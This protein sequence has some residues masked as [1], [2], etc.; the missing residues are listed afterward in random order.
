VV[1]ADTIR[2]TSAEDWD[3]LLETLADAEATKKKQRAGLDGLP[4]IPISIIISDLVS[5]PSPFSGILNKILMNSTCNPI[6][7]ARKAKA[8]Q[9][10]LL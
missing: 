8:S 7:L 9:Q 6:K 3:G 10:L 5:L 4:V 2:L 1:K